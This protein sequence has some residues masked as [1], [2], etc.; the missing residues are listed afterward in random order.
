MTRCLPLCGKAVKIKEKK[1]IREDEKK[2][3]RWA[4]DKKEDW[5]REEE[6]EVDHRKVE[7]MVPKWFHKWLKVFGKVESERMLVRKV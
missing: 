1:E 2:I 3:V 7:E 5:E 4:V 6:M